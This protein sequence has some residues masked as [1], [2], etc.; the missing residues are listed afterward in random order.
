MKYAS[1]MSRL[2]AE[3]IVNDSIFILPLGSLEQHGPHL[4][5]GTDY[6]TA[7]ELSR[8]VAL[9]IENSIILPGLPFGYSWVWRDIPITVTIR[10][11]TL[12][13]VL[14]E[15]AYSICR[16][17][18][19]ALVVINGHLANES[20]L[21]YAAR[22]L[23]DEIPLKFFYFSLP[24]INKF[25]VDSNPS[26]LTIHAEEIE[27]SL[28]LSV[29][30]DLVNMSL[31]K[32]EYP[33]RPKSYGCSA[34]SLGILSKSGVFGDPSVATKEKGE[35]YYEIMADFIFSVLKEE[36]IV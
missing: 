13:E 33:V 29:R 9:R 21:K 31:A 2:E 32:P 23:V 28:I 26:S 15:I 5:L 8:R 34:L 20:A 25:P 4:P 10:E 14:K 19:K 3:Q 36:K 27:T 16:F 6:Y 22:D 30:P 7:E 35:I 18:A 17:K 11:K 1:E 12:E 24:E